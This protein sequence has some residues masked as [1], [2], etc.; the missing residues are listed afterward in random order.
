MAGNDRD[1][2]P[3]GAAA[4]A[5]A[6]GQRAA[7]P[8]TLPEWRQGLAEYLAARTSRDSLGARRRTAGMN[9]LVTGGA[10][11]IGSSYVR[12]RLENHPDFSVRVL[13]KLTYA[14]RR[15]NLK[16]LDESRLELVVADI[17]D[18]EAVK[19]ALDGCDAIVNFAAETHVD[20]SIEAP[21]EFIQTDV[22]GTYVLLE[23]AREAGSG[24][25]RSRPTRST[26]RST[27][28]R[29]PRAPRS[30]PPRPT[31]LRRPAAT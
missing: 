17:V 25:C 30:T 29:S 19:A 22:F 2:R 10:G 11:F 16:G 15:E 14:G 20:R 26:A 1:A 24:T 3:P 18:A 7:D 21:G 23:A 4:G 31:R 12:H 28:A 13:D 8:I 6:A 27:R 5:L 9:V